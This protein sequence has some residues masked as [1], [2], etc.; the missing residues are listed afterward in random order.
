MSPAPKGPIAWMAKNPVA[1]NLLMAVLL[2]GGLLMSGR[3]KQELFPEFTLDLVTIEVPFP[4][5]S[6]AEVRP[7]SSRVAA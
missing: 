2:V 1:A 7:R 6:P 5:A 4:G 3:I